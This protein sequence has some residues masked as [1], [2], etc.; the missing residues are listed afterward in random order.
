MKHVSRVLLIRVS[1]ATTQS[2]LKEAFD[3]LH[4]EIDDAKLLS[5][6]HSAMHQNSGCLNFA[7]KLM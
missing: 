1:Q 6:H 5:S 3:Y 7:E 2:A 4:V